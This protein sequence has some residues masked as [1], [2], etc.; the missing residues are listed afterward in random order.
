MKIALST[1]SQTNSISTINSNFNKLATELQEKVLYRNNP[2][3]EPN[4]LGSDV[5]MNGKNLYNAGLIQA[6][7][8]TVDGQN[9]SIA[10][11]NAAVAK[12]ASDAASTEGNRILAEA[13]AVSALASK[14]SAAQ[15]A[16]DALATTNGWTNVSGSYGY[17]VPVPYT[18]GISIT[19]PTQTVEQNGVIYTP[20]LASLPFVTSGVFEVNDF[21]VV[22][23]ILSDT[24]DVKLFGAIGGGIVDDTVSIISA[25]TAAVARAQTGRPTTLLFPTDIYK[26]TSTLGSY[27]CSNLIID[28]NGSTLD[29]S[30]SG[31][32]GPLLEFTGSIGAYTPLSSSGVEG[33]YVLNVPT[34]GF[35]RGDW[36]KIISNSL[37]DASNTDSKLGELNKIP[38]SDNTNTALPAQTMYLAAPLATSYA[39]GAV[40]RV[41]KVSMLSN[42]SIRNGKIIGPSLIR[43][44]AIAIS[45]VYVENCNVRDVKIESFDSICIALKDTS[46]ILVSDCGFNHSRPIALGYGVSFIDASQD[47][48]VALCTFEDIRHALS[49]NNNPTTDYGIVRR[50]TF[51]DNTVTHSAKASVTSSVFVVDAMANTLTV[52]TPSSTF[53]T[54]RFVR[55][56]TDGVLPAGLGGEY[57][58]YLGTVTPSTVFTLHL[59][60]ADSVAL[61]NPVEITGA[62]TGVHTVTA[63]TGGDAVDTHG[64]ADFIT[65]SHNK[66]TGSSGSGINIECANAHVSDNQIIGSAAHGV[67]F[68]SEADRVGSVAIVDNEIE[69]SGGA[70]ILVSQ[71]TRGTSFELRHTVIDGNRIRYSGQSV[72]QYAF[73][74]GINIQGDVGTTQDSICITSNSVM[75]GSVGGIY[76]EELNGASIVGN[77]MFNNSGTGLSIVNSTKVVVTANTVLTPSTVTAPGIQLTGSN[78]SVVTSN[79]IGSVTGTVTDIGLFLTNSSSSVVTGNN[80]ITGFSQRLSLGSGAGHV[81]PTSSASVTFNPPSILNGASSSTTVTSTGAG[82]GDAVSVAF[83]TA[84]AGITLSAWV[85]S[86]DTV[87]ISFRN[88]TGATVDLASGTLRVSTE[89]I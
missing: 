23:S 46:G 28:L 83:S 44:T 13:A 88:D 84:L 62:G 56:T 19:T 36:V 69:K 65:I 33:E 63:Y 73:S 86:T 89:R 48:T 58:Y 70:G 5:D 35:V 43:D 76:V 17:E 4:E 41:A 49:T 79:V 20:Y 74:Q 32:T 21:R 29:A 51:T 8:L 64:G 68:H 31:L 82:V 7:M 80:A 47:G 3:G 60:L 52:L 30:T 77:S 81:G 18:A 67:Y 27:S 57:T 71:G 66:I 26:V 59:T 78:N 75:D 38:T 22:Q 53:T 9:I 25:I 45:L 15:S 24:L 87:T 12:T 37:W 2:I 10:E 11:I 85:S 6:D 34:S 39:T 40:A 14:E 50:I 42:L 1:V 16:I 61:V 54:T 55:L 72:G